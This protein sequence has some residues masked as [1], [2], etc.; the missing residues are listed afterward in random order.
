MF[1]CY[2]V[3]THRR[4]KD[5]SKQSKHHN[6][7]KESTSE[8]QRLI[9]SHDQPKITS[10]SL[11]LYFIMVDHLILYVSMKMITMKT[12]STLN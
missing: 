10:G 6:A 9:E 4:K 12:Q 7:V 3:H 2:E 8:Q 5:E 1:A 11:S